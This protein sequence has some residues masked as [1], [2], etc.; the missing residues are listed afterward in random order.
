[1]QGIEV[2]WEPTGWGDPGPLAEIVVLVL[3]L[4][5]LQTLVMW[6][7]RWIRY[8]WA[9]HKARPVLKEISGTSLDALP[10]MLRSR[11]QNHVVRVLEAGVGAFATC[12]LRGVAGCGKL[13]DFAMRRRQTRVYAEYKVGVLSL[14]TI[15]A[16]APFVGMFGTMIGIFNSLGASALNKSTFIALIA[17]RTSRAL[18]PA[19]LGLGIGVLAHTAHNCLARRIELLDKDMTEAS[20]L[21]LARLNRF[22]P[23]PARDD[24][25]ALHE[26]STGLLTGDPESEIPSD[27][28]FLV[29]PYVWMMVL[30]LLYEVVVGIHWHYVYGYF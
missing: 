29:T 28:V 27:R 16:I 10:G 9:H 3:A 5:L 13:A 30:Y 2:D 20:L 11:G 23:S 6:L 17:F 15:A 18:V 21:M 25:S 12:S 24:E 8:S 19:A 26:V 4:M 1:M 14:G 22:E 7:S